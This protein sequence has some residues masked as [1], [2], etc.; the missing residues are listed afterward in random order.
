MN[1]QE[2]ALEIFNL[3]WLSSRLITRKTALKY[4]IIHVNGIITAL[5]NIDLPVKQIEVVIEQIEFYQ[6]VKETIENFEK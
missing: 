1:V 2:K 4:A 5:S 6:I 3:Y